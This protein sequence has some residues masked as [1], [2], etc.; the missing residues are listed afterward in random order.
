MGWWQVMFMS[1]YDRG[2]GIWPDD[3]VVHRVL[4]CTRS[5]TSELRVADVRGLDVIHDVHV[6][7]REVHDVGGAAR[8][9]GIV[10]D[11]A[12]DV[13]RL[14]AGHLDVRLERLGVLGREGEGR[15][16]LDCTHRAGEG[17]RVWCV[18]V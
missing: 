18:R 12:K 14:R 13:P 5:L 17:G 1:V 8:R 2:G 7:L 16:A 4:L 9:R 11:G 10:H 3:K 15:G 6:N